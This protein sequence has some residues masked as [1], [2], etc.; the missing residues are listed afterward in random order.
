MPNPT[1]APAVPDP[2]DPRPD[3]IWL[4]EQNKPT[5]VARDLERAFG[6]PRAATY[7]V[8]MARGVMKWLAVRRDLIALKNMWRLRITR[9]LAEIRE[10]KQAR[11]PARLERLR[12]RLESLNECR[13]ELRALCHSERWRCPAF[14]GPAC[15]WAQRI[16][17]L[18]APPFPLRQW[19]RQKREVP[20]PSAEVAA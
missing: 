3:R 5:L 2:L 6:V 10:A 17:P 20:E 15:A 12:G 1:E 9:T 14:D 7:A 18:Q 19:L 16:G 13:Q 11:D 8:L 4:Y